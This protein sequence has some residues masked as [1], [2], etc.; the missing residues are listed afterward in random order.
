MRCL[1][2]AVIYFVSAYL[3]VKYIRPI[4]TYFAFVIL[5]LVM[6]SMVCWQCVSCAADLIER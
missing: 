4:L 6:T 1:K 2:S 3:V 5:V